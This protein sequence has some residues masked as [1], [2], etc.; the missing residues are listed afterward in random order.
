[1]DKIIG[2]TTI[3]R[4]KKEFIIDTSFTP[5]D[6]RF[7]ETTIIYGYHVSVVEMYSNIADAQSGHIKWCNFAKT[8]PLSTILFTILDA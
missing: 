7:Y 5:N 4:D 1:M 6:P 2:R 3:K 8:E